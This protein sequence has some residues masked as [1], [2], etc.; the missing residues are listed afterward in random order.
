MVYVIGV[1]SFKNPEQ[2]LI[3]IGF[4]DSWENRKGFYVSANPL[5]KFLFT[6]DGGI[7]QDEKNL[8]AYF[9]EF[10]YQGYGKEWFNY[11]EDIIEFFRTNDTIEKIRQIVG[12]P[13][14]RITDIPIPVN[15]VVQVLALLNNWG[16]KNK[17]MDQERQKLAHLGTFD[18]KEILESIKSRH[19]AD[20]PT[21][22]RLVTMW[23]DIQNEIKS[24]SISELSDSDRTKYDKEIEK[25]YQ[26]IAASN[27]F[28]INFR[29]FCNF[30]DQHK[31]NR[32]IIRQ[33]FDKILDVRFWLYYTYLGVVECRAKV[34]RDNLLSQVLVDSL[35]EKEVREEVVK[36]FDI[37][38]RYSLKDIKARLREI[39]TKFGMSKNAKASDINEWFRTKTVTIFDEARNRTNGFEILSLKEEEK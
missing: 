7:E 15:Q 24:Y 11:D 26:D 16:A 17:A 22:E 4:S 35:R 12:E 1:A 18:A 32:Y 9:K 25:F 20:F 23:F 34:F 38:V 14:E 36:V 29:V 5:T 8:H 21:I 39:Y 31:D 3:K 19:S 10:K 27:Q 13:E 30:L 28:H 37:K 2:R 6:I 33:L